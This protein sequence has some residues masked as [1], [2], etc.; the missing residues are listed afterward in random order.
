MTLKKVIVKQEKEVS[1]PII[2]NHSEA[3]TNL[4]IQT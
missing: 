3:L 4:A 2:V 1:R